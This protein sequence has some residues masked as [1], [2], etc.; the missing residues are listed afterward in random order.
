MSPSTVPQ[1]ADT[2]DT[3][4]L[5]QVTTVV[6]LASLGTDTVTLKATAPIPTVPANG[7]TDIP[8]T[9]TQCATDRAANNETAAVAPTLTVTNATGTY[10]THSFSYAFAL[11]KGSTLVETTRVDEGSGSTSYQITELLDAE[12]TYSWKVRAVL[13]DG[14]SD[15]YGPWSTTFTFTT[16]A[17]PVPPVPDVIIGTPTPT[18][19][20][21]G[22]SI[23]DFTP[24]FTVTNGTNTGT[25][26][27]IGT[28]YYEIQVATSRTPLVVVVTASTQARDRGKTNIA[29]RPAGSAYETELTASTTYYWRARGRNYGS[30]THFA[31]GGTV[32]EVDASPWSEWYVF[33]TADASATGANAPYNCCPPANRLS[34]VQQV[35]ADIGYPGSG[36][37]VR[38]LTQKVA[39]KLYA[40]DNRW[41]RRIND[42][43]PL[44]KDTV[45][46]K[47]DD[48]R[49]YSIDIVSGAES[50]NPKVHWDPHGFIGGTWVKP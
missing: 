24:H 1:L 12:T 19:P 10:V 46:Y 44:G 47:A 26:G 30:K 31:P 35:A 42:T 48:G 45:A 36:V 13:N 22:E 17:A 43:G 11:Y 20:I 4:G 18:W 28:V 50:S 16:A 32:I 29:L 33:K 27:D 39:E 7:A 37:D 38:T 6:N 14:T 21:D 9:T 3:S 2:S 8:C 15:T 34:V 41:G 25:A 5:V 23:T 40:E 49:P